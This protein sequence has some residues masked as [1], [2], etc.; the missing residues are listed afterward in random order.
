VPPPLLNT[1][2]TVGAHTPKTASSLTTFTADMEW[3]AD[4]K[5]HSASDTKHS[6]TAGMIYIA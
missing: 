2:Y 4:D 5:E 1:G 3:K 6:S